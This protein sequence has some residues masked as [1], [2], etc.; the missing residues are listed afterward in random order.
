MAK[1][2]KI[3]RVARNSILQK[4]NLDSLLK[5]GWQIK[6]SANQSQGY[7]FGKTCCLGSCFL[8]LALL[9][10]KSDVMEY[11]LE[12]DEPESEE[13]P[14]KEAGKSQEVKKES[15]DKE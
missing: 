10:R 12:R 2:Q 14:K 9:G 13:E 4:I 6:S 5:Q 11:I 3:V 15:K 1:Q 7:S 8:P